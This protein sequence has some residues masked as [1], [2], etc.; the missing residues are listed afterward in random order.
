MEKKISILGCGGFGLAL[1]HILAQKGV[2]YAWEYDEIRALLLQK[3]G[4]SDLIPYKLHKNIIVSHDIVA[5]VKG[6]DYIFI[7][8]PS[9]F[10]V[11]T[12]M[13]VK[14]HFGQETILVIGSKGLDAN[15]HRFL[16]EALQNKI[17]Q[18][19]CVLSGPMFAAEM[20]KDMPVVGTLAGKDKKKT[21]EIK[22][23]FEATTMFVET[24]EDV[25]GVS[26]VGALKNVYAIGSGVLK[27]LG[28]EGS[29]NAH[30][31][32]HAFK[33]M[34]SLLSIYKGNKET[35]LS[36]AGFGDLLL[37]CTSNK[38]RNFRFGE[39]IGKGIAPKNIDMTIEGKQ[40]LA[41]LISM[42]K[43]KKIQ[44]PL[45]NALY[46]IVYKNR[47]PNHLAELLQ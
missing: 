6:A 28:L 15:S 23:L 3:T 22:K 12:V 29:S 14:R 39:M 11:E 46:E 4:K 34:E 17:S 7:A 20:V 24:S 43:I 44:I 42:L 5:T 30:Y 1:A 31:L 10:V 33:E 27:G 37:T 40:T 25:V 8:I 21:E 19:I 41:V 36:P 2:V 38:S 18:K 13:A 9:Q 47:D 16:Y 32:S 45:L 35:L 26:L